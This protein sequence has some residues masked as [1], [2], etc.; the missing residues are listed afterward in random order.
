MF[1]AGPE[2]TGT[3]VVMRFKKRRPSPLAGEKPTRDILPR[4]QGEPVDDLLPV[5]GEC[6]RLSLL[7]VGVNPSPWTAAVNAPFAHPGNR[8]W[9]SLY[10][11]GV[12]PH[13]VDCSR[14]LA[15]EDFHMM[16]EL[17]IGITNFVSG[18]ATSKASELTTGQLREG[19][20]WVRGVVDKLEPEK[21]AIV[22]I[23]AHRQAFR[24]PKAKLGRQ[25]G[26]FIP[27]GWPATVELWVVPQPSGLN[28]HE[29]ID[30]LAE[31]WKDVVQ[32]REAKRTTQRPPGG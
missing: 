23:T 18:V 10:R 4:F 12:I 17:R 31:K 20:Q 13:E 1:A 19:A 28:A 15:E 24:K 11:G 30:S 25:E 8:F 29:T 3:V 6:E 2:T 7:I 5:P 21:V 26:E 9:P 16:E 32:R 14:G 22:G 27:E